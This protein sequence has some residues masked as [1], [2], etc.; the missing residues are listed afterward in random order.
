[1][2]N[3]TVFSQAFR[4][5]SRIPSITYTRVDKNINIPEMMVAS[6]NKACLPPKNILSLYHKN[7]CWP[8]IE[9]KDISH[10]TVV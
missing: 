6:Y 2:Y 1:M 3:F 10:Y 4:A 5:L 8:E 9:Q 7:Q